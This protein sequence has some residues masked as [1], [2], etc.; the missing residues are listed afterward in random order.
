MAF[1]SLAKSAAGI[2]WDS[3]GILKILLLENNN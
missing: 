2:I 1:N 3:D